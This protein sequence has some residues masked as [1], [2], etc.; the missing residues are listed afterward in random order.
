MEN[1]AILVYCSPRICFREVAKWVRKKPKRH[2][3][4]LETWKVE[5]FWLA[6]GNKEVTTKVKQLIMY[7][8]STL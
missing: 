8:V 5:H 1:T 7:E 4:V 3:A 6:D 2:Q